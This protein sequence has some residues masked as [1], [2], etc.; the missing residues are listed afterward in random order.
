MVTCPVAVGATLAVRVK[1]ARPAT[2]RS[3]VVEIEPD[4]A[5]A[6]Q[7]AP[8]VA[9]QCQLGATRAAGSRSCTTTSAT[10]L[11]PLFVTTSV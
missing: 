10:A 7:I 11:G 1:M 2:A 9:P 3:T 8:P 5:T 6:P 4:P